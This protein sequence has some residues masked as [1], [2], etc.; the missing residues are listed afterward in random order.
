VITWDE[1]SEDE[2]NFL[3]VF[4]DEWTSI[5]QLP[6]PANYNL[7]LG[8]T[9]W[10]VTRG[11]I[12]FSTGG[13]SEYR[14]TEAGRALVQANS[15][16]PLPGTPEYAAFNTRMVAGQAAVELPI[17]ELESEYVRLVVENKQLAA[18]RDAALARAR[19]LEALIA[20]L[21]KADD[22]YVSMANGFI[23]RFAEFDQATDAYDAYCAAK[24]LKADADGA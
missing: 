9:F 2:R 15:D 3:R 13:A 12:E 18:E 23:F 11:V 4:P 16:S 22:Y 24:P 6:S 17:E 19:E 20:A 10:L 1:L 21:S 8:A 7:G 14:R 5:V